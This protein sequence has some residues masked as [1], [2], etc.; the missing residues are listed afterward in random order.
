MAIPIGYCRKIVGRSD[1]ALSGVSIHLGTIDSDFRG[2]VCVFLTN[3]SRV[4]HQIKK[5]DLI[6]QIIFEKCETVKLSEFSEY[7]ELPGNDRGS[8][9]FGSTGK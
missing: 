5:G 9:G 3:T 8:K 2:V 7:K 4:E 1:L 6:G